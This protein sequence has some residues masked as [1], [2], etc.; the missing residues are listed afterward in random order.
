MKKFVTKI[1]RKYFRNIIFYLKLLLNQLKSF[2]KYP[3]YYIREYLNIINSTIS[4]VLRNFPNIK[5]DKI[6]RKIRGVYYNFDF[7]F[8]PRY[9]GMFLGMGTTPIVE[10]LIRYVKE[11]TVFIDA[12]ANIGY[13]S[14]IGSALV[15]KKGEVHSFEP[16]PIYFKKI[17]EF[18]KMNKKYAIF[19]NSFALGENIG[20]SQINIHKE[21]D[22]IGLN[23]MVPGIL[24]SQQIKETITIEV[25]RLDDYIIEKDIKNIS[26][27]KIDVEGYE[28]FLLKGLEKYFERDKNSLPPLVIEITPSAYPLLGISLEDLTN[29]MKIYNY[30]AWTLDEKKKIYLMKMKEAD[31]VLFK[32]I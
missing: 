12:G 32:Q 4:T 15:G 16:V 10:V 22:V 27:I 1:S 8:A 5:I 21:K 17:V 30:S 11:G 28:Y 25:K 9:R 2:I 3:L 19:T 24:S 14:A 18:A 20:T 23:T 31:D 13:L 26:L 7:K 29:F 6:T